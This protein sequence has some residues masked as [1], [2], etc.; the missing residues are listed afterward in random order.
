MARGFAESVVDA[1]AT[2]ANWRSLP[3]LLVCRID[4]TAAVA[5]L[6]ILLGFDRQ[7]GKSIIVKAEARLGFQ[8]HLLLIRKL[9]V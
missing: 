9:P 6:R 4:S 8:S 1:V 2:T 7:T 3:F 5:V